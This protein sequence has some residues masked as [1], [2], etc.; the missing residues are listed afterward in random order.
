[1][2][3]ILEA[4]KYWQVEGLRWVE[5]ER[6]SEIVNVE[7]VKRVEGNRVEGKK[8]RVGESMDKER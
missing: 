4:M 6:E 5:V 8:G 2:S 1:M 7:G 3:Q